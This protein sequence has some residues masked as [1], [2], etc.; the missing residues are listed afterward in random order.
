MLFEAHEIAD[1]VKETCRNRCVFHPDLLS[2]FAPAFRDNPNSQSCCYE[3][4]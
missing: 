2:I 4:Y 1:S 3:L